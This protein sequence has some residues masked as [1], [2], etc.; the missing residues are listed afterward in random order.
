[1]KEKAVKILSDEF[2]LSIED[3]L[4][5]YESIFNAMA[6]SFAKGKNLNIPEFGKFII[7]YKKNHEGKRFKSIKFSPVKKI[8]CEVNKNYDDLKP[9][10]LK[11]II[12]HFNFSPVSYNNLNGHENEINEDENSFVSADIEEI[13]DRELEDLILSEEQDNSIDVDEEETGTIENLRIPGNLK[14]LHDEIEM[15]KEPGKTGQDQ[16]NIFDKIFTAPVT[17][18][19]PDLSGEKIDI[20]L[21]AVDNMDEL[22]SFDDIFKPVPER[23]QKPE[24]RQ[25]EKEKSPVP[26]IELDTLKKL[27]DDINSLSGDDPNPTL[28]EKEELNASTDSGGDNPGEKIEDKGFGTAEETDD[29]SV[30]PDK[31][32]SSI[33]KEDS[34]AKDRDRKI[35]TLLMIFLIII[36]GLIIAYG[37]LN[38]TIFRDQD[39]LEMKT[40]QIIPA[41]DERIKPREEISSPGPVNKPPAVRQTIEKDIIYNH[42]DAGISVQVGAFKN[43]SNADARFNMLK[44]NGMN[45]F[46]EEADLGE[47]GKF[48]RVKIGYFQSIE[49]AR[50]EAGKF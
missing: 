28:N 7:R 18:N 2:G 46:I 4:H 33:D 45:A 17:E 6:E 50:E 38:A 9:V 34:I 16:V 27:N 15:D 37:I 35:Y 48:Y 43:R 10:E 41:A 32:Q 21:S 1:M 3:A 19:D 47:K 22:K 42:T 29:N 25:S 14:E 12:R 36:C 49:E 31:K 24:S 23:I 20:K 13:D 5:I 44:K 26:G 11:E 40:G 39:H 8:A 30:Q